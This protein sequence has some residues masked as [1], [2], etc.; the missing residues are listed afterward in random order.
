MSS[1]IATF[2]KISPQR[3]EHH[4]T[5]H[6]FRAGDLD[7]TTPFDRNAFLICPTLTPLYYTPSY[8]L[9]NAEQQRRYNQLVALSTNEL[10]GAFERALQ[11]ILRNLSIN[12]RLPTNLRSLLPRFIEDET[13]HA[14]IWWRLNRLAEPGWYAADP[15]HLVHLP[16][17]VRI[18]L[19]AL[20]SHPSPFPVGLWTTL[21]LEEHSME[22]TR[23]CTQCAVGIEPRFLAEYQLHAH[24]EARHIQIDWHMLELLLDRLSPAMLRL[25][26]HLLQMIVSR[27]F[28][29]PV[30]VAI[31]VL[32]QLAREFP[33]LIQ[34]MPKFQADLATLSTSG[35]YRKMI[36]SQQANPVTFGF[37]NRLPD[38][39]RIF[40][41][42]S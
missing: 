16:P 36:F 1:A 27:F 7:W 13:C 22:I 12:K 40:A 30:N 42:L 23:R 19:R 6:R 17:M 38:A 3:L 8:E 41:D 9:L 33:E 14:D 25:N 18:L 35:E 15:M 29:R 2:V 24:D 37:I 10:V 26:I 31:R 21:I 39:R 28:L 20:V 32:A 5:G 11:P 34:R 4:A